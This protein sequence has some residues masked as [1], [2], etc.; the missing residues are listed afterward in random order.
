VTVK[1]TNISPH[2]FRGR[3]AEL[4]LVELF[5]ARMDGPL[6]ARANFVQVNLTSWLSF[7][8]GYP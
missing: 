2:H 1:T 6:L 5:Q 7:M 4:N 3:D 8:T